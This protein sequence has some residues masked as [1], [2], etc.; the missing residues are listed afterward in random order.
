MGPEVSG[1]PGRTSAPSMVR[2]WFD[3]SG[4]IAKFEIWLRSA[5]FGLRWHLCFHI[6]DTTLPQEELA[7]IAERIAQEKVVE[8]AAPGSKRCYERSARPGYC[9]SRAI[10]PQYIFCAHGRKRDRR[11]P[12]VLFVELVDYLHASQFQN[13]AITRSMRALTAR[14]KGPI[15]DTHSPQLR[16]RAFCVTLGQPRTFARGA[17]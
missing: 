15:D 14:W 1:V 12:Y 6:A 8:F 4:R 3:L 2:A 5:H 17:I 13:S 16:S 10:R 11:S 9:S 7:R